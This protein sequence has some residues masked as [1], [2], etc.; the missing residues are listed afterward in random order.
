[1]GGGDGVTAWAGTGRRTRAE[2]REP[3]PAGR[4][5][6]DQARRRERDRAGRVDRG[7]R[8][9]PRSGEPTGQAVG[10]FSSST[11]ATFF[12]CSQMA[13]NRAEPSITMMPM[14][15]PA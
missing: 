2:K 1:M 6:R 14:P 5:E 7:R 11:S 4:R 8:G 10:S 15:P 9:T 12:P 3:E 13:P